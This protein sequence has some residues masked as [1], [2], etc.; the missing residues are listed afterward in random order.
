VEVQYRQ[1]FLKDL[2]TLKGSPAYQRIFEIA[3]ATLPN[4]QSLQEVPNVKALML[5][6]CRDIQTA[7]VLELVIIG[8]E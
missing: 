8:L 4:T 2:K 3:F 7:T 5:K 1:A 6:L